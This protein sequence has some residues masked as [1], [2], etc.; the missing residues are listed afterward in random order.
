MKKLIS[1]YQTFL[2]WLEKATM[3][4][5]MIMAALMFLNTSTGIIVDQVVGNSLV[6]IEEVNTL[7]F[8]WVVFVG[9][10]SN[11]AGYFY[12]Y[13]RRFDIF[14]V[15]PCTPVGPA[16]WISCPDADRG[17]GNGLLWGQ[18]GPICRPVSDLPLS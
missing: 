18:D 15:G 17:L 5:A 14:R 11:T 1:G 9:A 13:G 4:L 16:R 3:A 8:A 12:A 10:G 6:W 2:D 7:L